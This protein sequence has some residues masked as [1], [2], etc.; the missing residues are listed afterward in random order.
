MGSN[1]ITP[2]DIDAV[3]DWFHVGWIN[4]MADTAEGDFVLRY[5][6]LF[7]AA[8]ASVDYVVVVLGRFQADKAR[9][10]LAGGVTG[11]GH[12]LFPAERGMMLI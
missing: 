3:S 2:Q 11:Q 6:P 7:G 12:E 10:V 9:E 4:T 5:V 8:H 1:P